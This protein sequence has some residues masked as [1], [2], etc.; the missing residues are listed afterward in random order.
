MKKY[1]GLALLFV[2]GSLSAQNDSITFTKAQWEKQKITKGIVWRHCHF[3]DRS[4]FASNQNINILEIKLNRRNR[5]AF[6]YEHK[7]LKP[8]SEFGQAANAIAAINGTFFDVKNGGSVDYLKVNDSVI[9]TNR[10]WQNN[11][12]ARHQKAA[13]VVKKRKLQIAKWDGS[14]DWESKLKAKDI[15]LTGP[16]LVLNKEAEPLDTGEFNRARHP[17]SAIAIPGKKKV[18]FITVDGRHENAAGMSLFERTKIMQWLQVQHGINLDG[19]G[20]T[21]LWLQ[22]QGVVNY[23]SD[24]KK[25]DHEGQRKVAN[26][27]LIKQQ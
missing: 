11:E 8:T 13:L 9:A 24:N 2:Y 17:R 18:L 27:V 1:F 12:R 3:T 23:P 19:G 20:S 25:W 6:G 10:L 22:Q 5:I 16:L 14:A 15:M 26:V 7:L 21:T 4:L